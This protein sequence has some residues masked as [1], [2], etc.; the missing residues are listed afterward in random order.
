MLVTSIFSFSYNVFNG[1]LFQGW[2][3]VEKSELCGKGLNHTTIFFAIN[4][5]I[6]TFNSLPND[7]PLDQSK[8]KEVA[9]DKINA[10]KKFEFVWAMVENIL[11]KGENAGY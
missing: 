10:A 5:R 1:H 7:K 8:F 6:L 3:Q 9:D 2:N 11:G 4:V